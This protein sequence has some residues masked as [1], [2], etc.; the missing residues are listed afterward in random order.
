M[1]AE[2]IGSLYTSLKI[3]Y[4]TNDSKE[5]EDFYSYFQ[6]TAN[7][8]RELLT[9]FLASPEYMEYA[10]DSLNEVVWVAQLLEEEPGE[11][12]HALTM[13]LENISKLQETK[14]NAATLQ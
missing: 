1:L 13:L 4:S 14:R 3:A 8:G 5:A 6:K 9:F 12:D 10:L 7:A 11:F 2:N